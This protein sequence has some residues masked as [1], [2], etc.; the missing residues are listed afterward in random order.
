M[1]P[2]KEP[3]SSHFPNPKRRRKTDMAHVIG[4]TLAASLTGRLLKPDED[5]PWQRAALRISNKELSI[6]SREAEQGAWL[7]N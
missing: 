2:K 4:G 3:K 7:D 1:V 5:D 6:P